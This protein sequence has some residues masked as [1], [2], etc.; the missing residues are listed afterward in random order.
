[1]SVPSYAE[2]RLDPTMTC[3]LES[4][5]TRSTRFVSLVDSKVGSAELSELGFFRMVL[6]FGS[7]MYWA[8]SLAWSISSAITASAMSEPEDS[9]SMARL[10]SPRT[11]MMPPGPKIYIALYA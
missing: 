4:P 8:S 7:V 2:V 9:H 11:V 3:L 5:S 10:G 1:M 6:S